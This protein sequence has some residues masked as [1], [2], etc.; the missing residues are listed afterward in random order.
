M[1]CGHIHEAQ[2]QLVR[3]M[4]GVPMIEPTPAVELPVLCGMEHGPAFFLIG[5]V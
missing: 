3:M 2:V 5:G 4:R 1:K